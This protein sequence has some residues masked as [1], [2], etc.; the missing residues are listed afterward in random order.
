MVTFHLPGSSTLAM[1]VTQLAT[2]VNPLSDADLDLPY[3][4]RVHDEGV[5]MAVFG[6]VHELH[7]LAV[8]LQQT[9]AN[10]NQPGTAVQRLLAQKQGGYRH[11]QAVL[12]GISEKEYDQ[13]PA[14]DE[15]SL[16]FVFGH[17]VGAERWFYTLA[18]VGLEHSRA[19]TTPPPLADDEPEKLVDSNEGFAQFREG[20]TLADMQ[21]YY[22]N[23]HGRI[24]QTFSDVTDDELK[25]PTPLWWEDEIFPI[26]HRL[27]RFDAHLQQHLIQAKKTCD[28]IGKLPTEA[29]R[30][31]RHLFR[32]LAD[33]E[34]LQIGTSPLCHPEQTA[35]AQIIQERAEVVTTICQQAGAHQKRP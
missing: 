15:W 22:E 25:A 26:Q 7:D 30:L 2:A 9:R 17:L 32:A 3:Q 16:R 4:W 27:E 19:G 14:P 29:S 12:L 24:V 10:M 6:T 11:L 20:C 33:V 5:R 28:Q 34:G 8:N 21:T 13:A 31:V 18:H 35:L 23:L 1:A